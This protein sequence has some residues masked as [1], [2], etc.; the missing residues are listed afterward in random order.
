MSTEA[1]VILLV[2]LLAAGTLLAGRAGIRS[3]QQARKVVF[4]RTRRSYMLVGWQWLALALVLLSSTVAS[5]FFGEPLA[6][7]ILV[8]SAPTGTVPS[9]ILS[10]RTPTPLGTNLNQRT[11]T[12]APSPTRRQTQT[13]ISSRTTPEPASVTPTVRAASTSTLPP[14]RTQPPTATGTI[15]RTPNPSPT[16]DLSMLATRAAS[17]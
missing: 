2:A 1:I 11:A 7:Q 4:Y 9:A 12:A 16:Q 14:T 17:T 15:T 10:T 3:I 6:N 8:P 13:E 5:A